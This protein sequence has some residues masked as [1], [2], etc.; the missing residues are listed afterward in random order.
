MAFFGVLFAFTVY[1]FGTNS[2]L[3]YLCPADSWGSRTECAD[4]GTCYDNGSISPVCPSGQWVNCKSVKYYTAQAGGEEPGAIL[5]KICECSQSCEDFGKTVSSTA[6]VN[7]GGAKST[8]SCGYTYSN[9]TCSLGI[10]DVCTRRYYL[11][12][13]GDP[14]GDPKKQGLICP[15]DVFDISSAGGTNITA[16][17]GESVSLGYQISAGSQ[18][19]MVNVSTE[20]SG[21]PDGATC[22][23]SGA[24]NTTVY[25]S[26]GPTWGSKAVTP[27]TSAVQT[28]NIGVTAYDADRPDCTKTVTY[29]V[30]VK[31]S[32]KMVCDSQWRDIP[33]GPNAYYSP[34]PAV[35]VYRNNGAN[36][37]N[38]QIVA[39]HR[40]G[41]MSDSSGSWRNGIL[42]T[43]CNYTGNDT[44]TTC[45]W[46]APEPLPYNPGS[47]GWQ[48]YIDYTQLMASAGSAIAEPYLALSGNTLL[49]RLRFTNSS[50]TYRHSEGS[51]GFSSEGNVSYPWGQPT[52]VV[53]PAGRTITFNGGGSNTKYKCDP[54]AQATYSY[55]V[56]GS[57]NFTAQRNGSLPPAQ[58]IQI[59]N[60]GNQ[61]LTLAISESIAWA[62][63]NRTSLTIAAG[64]TGTVSVSI[65]ST[66]LT[67]GSLTGN[68]AFSHA[69][70]GNKN[71]AINYEVTGT[72]PVCDS[73]W[74]EVPGGGVTPSQPVGIAVPRNP[75]PGDTHPTFDSQYYDSIFMS[76]RAIGATSAPHVQACRFNGGNNCSFDG[77]WQSLG[78]STPYPPYLSLGW[79]LNMNVKDAW[80]NTYQRINYLTGWQP[81]SS[82]AGPT[83]DPGSMAWGKPFRTTDKVGRTWQFSKNSFGRVMYACGSSVCVPLSFNSASSSLSSTVVAIGQSFTAR[84]DFGVKNIDSADVKAPAGISC[85]YQPGSS[86]GNT[87][88]TQ[89]VFSC[90]AQTGAQS[91]AVS[92]DLKNNTPNFTCAQSNNIGNISINRALIGLNPSAFSFSKNVGS[93]APAAQNLTI[94]NTGQGNLNFT[95]RTNQSWCRVNGQNNG[96]QVTGSLGAGASQVISVSVDN[97]DTAGTRSCGIAVTDPDAGNNPQNIPIT[98]E[99]NASPVY[100]YSVTPSL[101]FSGVQ[102]GTLPTSKNITVTNTGNQALTITVSEAISWAGVNPSSV[103]ILPGQNA[104][105]AVNISSTALS[106][107]SYTGSVQFT[108]AQ[109]GNKTAS[110]SLQITPAASPPPPP[111]QP[112][113]V[114]N[115]S[116]CEQVIISWVDG[117]S[118]EDGFRIYR[119]STNNPLSADLIATVGENQTSYSYS[120]TDTSPY[121][122]F[123]S[124]YSNLGG[125][126]SR[127]LANPPGVATFGCSPNISNSDKDIV[128][129]VPVQGPVR[130]WANTGDDCGLSNGAP[131][132]YNIIYQAGDVVKF[133]INICNTSGNSDV[134]VQRV[135]DTIYNMDMPAGGWNARYQDSANP[136][137]WVNITPTLSGSF[138]SKVL[139]FNFPANYKVPDGESR[140]LVYEAKLVIADPNAEFSRFYNRASIE[141]VSL[142]P[143]MVFSPAILFFKQGSVPERNEI[144]PS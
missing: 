28:Y 117:S 105:V 101:S 46:N 102:N 96:G 120:I 53:D 144:P 92:C 103:T 111:P 136:A 106:P 43:F 138:P 27:L 75:A 35:A 104:N 37:F 126:S 51:S 130:S 116:V 16:Y 36:N 47:Y 40:G 114:N 76:V 45:V 19:N 77:T 62:N 112:P 33:F 14:V 84:C 73:A 139:R 68:V 5:E 66:N 71:T 127:V 58:N 94:T 9:T 4:S 17:M 15:A 48:P 143:Q 142:P 30:T 121:Y 119:N 107:A 55:T 99:V 89:A 52:S 56:T 13:S 81:V 137:T 31:P 72:T 69:Q 82:W 79:S 12:S 113:T 110:I 22:T 63:I 93:P 74:H 134:T 21:C 129:I 91:G 128:G 54:P 11:N 23:P 122:Y 67:P 140:K 10:G 95:M 20:V 2:S 50:Q 59:T 49:T 8:Y 44:S 86:F 108:H 34:G 18:K 1:F 7:S 26:D 61:S 85:V 133:E 88:P 83:A 78:A 29:S 57:L 125:E 132:G 109:A 64:Q 38:K 124:A 39:M 24:T 3:A 98:Y 87:N 131:A 32:R 41:W 118:N 6:C 123:V 65:S 25:T 60:T 115:T 100:S 80:N 42:R 135:V 70:A 90:T 97:Y 141:A